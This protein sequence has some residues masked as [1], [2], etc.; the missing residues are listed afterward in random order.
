MAPRKT[1]TAPV[2]NT[3]KE[4]EWVSHITL[5]LTPTECEMIVKLIYGSTY[6]QYM[7]PVADKI[8]RQV[9]A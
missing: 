9:F 5:Q 1:T 7:E 8:T 3:P 2:V 6:N 4:P